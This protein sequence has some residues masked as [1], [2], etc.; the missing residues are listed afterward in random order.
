MQISVT[1]LRTPELEF[2]DN[3]TYFTDPRLG[4]A[5]AGPFSLRFGRAHKAQ[6]R[7]GL[8]GPQNLINDARRWYKRCEREV[9]TGK[10]GIPMYVDF[11]GFE[12]AFQSFVV[13]DGTWDIDISKKL[14]E[15]LDRSGHARFEGVLDAYST[16]ITKLSREQSIDVITCC[17]PSEVITSCWSINRTLSRIE[18]VQ[19]KKARTEE[20]DGQMSFEAMWAPD[21]TPEAL[22]Q[23]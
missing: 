6:I 7:L 1:E 11:P 2:G 14:S 8:V 18:R 17:L 13:L 3:K 21:D 20:E 4:L 23:R 10:A 5:S 12:R 9:F 19:L 22:L 15:V 16:A